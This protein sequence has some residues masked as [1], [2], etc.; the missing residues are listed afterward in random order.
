MV[1][2]KDSEEEAIGDKKEGESCSV[3]QW[4]GEDRGFPEMPKEDGHYCE[5]HQA[6]PYDIEGKTICG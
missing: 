5:V 1:M 4:G 3:P 6:E 2:A